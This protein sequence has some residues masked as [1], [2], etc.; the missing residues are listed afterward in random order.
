MR[1]YF[2]KRILIVGLA[3]SGLACAFLLESLG[4]TLTVTDMAPV[5]KLSP[6]VA[7]IPDS[8]RKILGGH[9]GIDPADYD[10][11]VISP[12]VAWDGAL[13]IA[14]RNAGVETISEVEL[15]ATLV[16]APIIA[17]TGSNGK[18]TTTVLIGAI[19]KEAGLK[20][21]IGGNIGTPLTGAVGGDYDWIVAEISSFQLEGIKTFRPA[22]A[23]ILNITPDHLDR[24]KTFERYTAIK[25]RIFENQKSGDILIVNGLDPAASG[26]TPPA[27][28]ALKKFAVADAGG[29]WVDNDRV[30]AKRDG[31]TEELYK[32][33]ALHLAGEHNRENSMAAATAALCAGATP[34]AIGDA[35]KKFIGLPHRMEKVATIAGVLYINDSK[36]TNVDATVKSLAGYQKN[37]ALIAGGS[38]KGADFGPLADAIRDHAIGVV[39]IGETSDDI[40]AALENFEPKIKADNL[41]DAVATASG[42][43]KEGQTL[44]FSPACASFDMFDNFEERGDAFRDAV[45]I[46]PRERENAS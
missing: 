33:G 18:S 22:I 36:G 29:A 41:T 26:V 28:V 31:E 25:K 7:A 17:I 34:A 32:L 12:G 38:S 16:D 3:R 20:V 5:G 21:Y 14:L 23:L 39:L 30:I 11:A 6:G 44:L 24:H 10:L 45:N 13:P 35:I 8:V 4:A 37:V 19:L 1:D 40:F 9:D 27:T 42:W 46:L 2:D 15:A 43:L